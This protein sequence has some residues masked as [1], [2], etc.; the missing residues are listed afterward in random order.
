[1]KLKLECDLYFTE[2]ALMPLYLPIENETTSVESD[3]VKVQK[4]GEIPVTED[5]TMKG[6]HSP[7]EYYVL[8]CNFFIQGVHC[9]APTSKT[10]DVL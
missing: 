8:F 2:R 5:L 4:R 9:C 10:K 6:S 7:G 3:V 1:M